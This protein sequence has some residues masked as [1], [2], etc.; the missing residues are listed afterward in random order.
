MTPILISIKGKRHVAQTIEVCGV[1][2][3]V[4]GK[5]LK[6]ARIHDEVWLDSG[7]LPSPTEIVEKLRNAG[8][9]PDVFTFT[10]RI[11]DLSSRYPYHFEWVNVA[12]ATIESYRMWFEKDIHRSARKHIRKAQREGIIAEIT[13]YNDALIEGICSIFNEMRVRQGKKFWHYGKSFDEV[14]QESGTYL[15]RS[16]FIGA[17]LG[18]ELVGFM[19][20]VIDGEVGTMMQILSKTSHFPKR[21]NNALI[22]KAVEFCESKGIKYLIYGEHTYGKKEKSTLI[23]FKEKNGFRKIELPRYYVPLTAKGHF[24]IKFG[25]HKGWT[26]LIPRWAT[27]TAIHLRSKYYTWFTETPKNPKGSDKAPN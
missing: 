25:I 13:P 7:K 16:V 22:S 15:D 19:K 17:H 9:C 20:I 2:L 21:P 1:V 3:V 12:A 18:S 11:S 14:K 5:I 23:D 24:A 27:K 10:Q 4:T 6:V 26:N 8:K